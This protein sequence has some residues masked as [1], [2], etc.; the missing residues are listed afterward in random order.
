M[1]YDAG[2]ATTTHLHRGLMAEG[3]PLLHQALSV[4]WT[5]HSPRAFMATCCA[6]LGVT[7][8]E[9]NVLGRW[10]QNSQTP[11]SGFSVH[12]YRNSNCLSSQSAVV[13]M[14]SAQCWELQELESFLEGADRDA[15]KR[16]LMKLDKAA[17]PGQ[18]PTQVTE[19]QPLQSQVAPLEVFQT[20]KLTETNRTPSLREHQ[21]ISRTS[22]E[23]A[24]RRVLCLRGWSVQGQ[25]LTVG[26]FP[27]WTTLC[28]RTK[29]H[30]CRRSTSTKKCASAV[31]QPCSLQCHK[32]VAQTRIHPRTSS[33]IW[34]PLLPPSLSSF[35]LLLFSA[36]RL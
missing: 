25:T 31:A 32:I 24:S 20:M 23:G 26:W 9:R 3:Q 21:G 5:P 14:T 2:L 12:L 19:A 22:V 10:A 17:L 6:A 35:R 30:S 13:V 36:L 18:A 34:L 7:K 29:A 1:S 15:I 27:E 4:Y 33:K 11:T 28:T 16:Q 8:A